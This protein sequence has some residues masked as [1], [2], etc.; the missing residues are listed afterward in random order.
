[1]L[2]DPN[3]LRQ[4][5]LNMLTNAVKFTKKGEIIVES[6]R[7][8]HESS[9]KMKVRFSVKDTGIGIPKDKCKR[10][11]NPYQQADA[12]V[13]RNYGG[14]GLGLAICKSLVEKMGGQIGVDSEF[15]KGTT[16]RFEIPFGIFQGHHQEEHIPKTPPA[17]RK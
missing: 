10:I 13:S 11:F 8:V 15:A 5:V 2:G 1:M 17:A 9:G 7:V 6:Q 12:S 4:V 16:F 3:R 14:T